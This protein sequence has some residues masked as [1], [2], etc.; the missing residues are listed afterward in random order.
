MAGAAVVAPP[1][2]GLHIKQIMSAY[3]I[4]NNYVTLLFGELKAAQARNL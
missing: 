4:T 3:V 1:A 2:L